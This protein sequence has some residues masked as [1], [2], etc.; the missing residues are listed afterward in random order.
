MYNIKFDGQNSEDFGLFIKS[1]KRNLKSEFTVDS[2]KL[3]FKNGSILYPDSYRNFNIV[4]KATLKGG[5]VERRQQARQIANWLNVHDWREL[6][7]EDEADVFY[8]AICVSELDTDI[9]YVDEFEIEFECKPF[10]YSAL[11]RDI[12]LGDMIFLGSDVA[13]GAT[14]SF[15][16][17]ADGQVTFPLNSNVP[18]DEY[19][20]LV[21]VSNSASA[22]NIGGMRLTNLD[23]G[24]YVV[25]VSNRVVYKLDGENVVNWMGDFNKVFEELPWE[26]SEVNID[27]TFEGLIGTVDMDFN[28]QNTYI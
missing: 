28:F 20:I 4:F 17:S 7:L 1:R 16:F 12:L 8:K 14:H 18:I 25:G 3:Q 23:A 11:D 13:L 22:I 9:S 5:L 2:K 26:L 10:K 24:Q 15:S 19:N 27:V 21:T 6:I